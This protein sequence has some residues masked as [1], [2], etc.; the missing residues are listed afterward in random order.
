MSELSNKDNERRTELEGV[1]GFL[2][3]AVERLS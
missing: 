1:R 3:L 2:D